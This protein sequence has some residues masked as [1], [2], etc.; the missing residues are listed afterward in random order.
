MTPRTNVVGAPFAASAN[1]IYT[2][3][4]LGCG[5]KGSKAFHDV[6]NNVLAYV[7]IFCPV[8]IV[9]HTYFVRTEKVLD[10]KPRLSR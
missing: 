6:S 3:L 10:I 2:R 4:A 9:R 1:N 7:R 5:D 8:V